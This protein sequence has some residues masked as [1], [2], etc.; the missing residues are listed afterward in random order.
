MQSSSQNYQDRYDQRSEYENRYA[1]YSTRSDYRNVYTHDANGKVVWYAMRI[2]TWR[3]YYDAPDA[4]TNVGYAYVIRKPR[5]VRAM[6]YKSPSEL[7]YHR[8]LPNYGHSQAVVRA[9]PAQPLP[10][11]E[12]YGYAK[13]LSNAYRRA[14]YIRRQSTN[15]LYPAYKAPE[16]SYIYNAYCLNPTIVNVD[17]TQNTEL[18]VAEKRDIACG[19][20]Q[21]RISSDVCKKIPC[22]KH[23]NTKKLKHIETIRPVTAETSMETIVIEE[24]EYVDEEV[25]PDDSHAI[26][27]SP[28]SVTKEVMTETIEFACGDQFLEMLTVDSPHTAKIIYSKY[29]DSADEDRNVTD[30]SDVV[31]FSFLNIS[32]FVFK[33]FVCIRKIFIVLSRYCVLT[34]FFSVP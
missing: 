12:E 26:G 13:S 25:G 32:A 21:V 24:I 3:N 30:N 8:E 31:P 20:S 16:N 1:N 17:K 6:P 2:P 27:I 19:N 7:H 29:D 11:E 5:N 33:C 15:P 23:K 10:L 9:Q 14:Y 4:G 34:K 22:R 28:Q 18:D